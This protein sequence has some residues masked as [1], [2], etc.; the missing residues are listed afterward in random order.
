MRLDLD[1]TLESTSLRFIYRIYR[2]LR[3]SIQLYTVPVVYEYIPVGVAKNVY[4]SPARVALI[5][6]AVLHSTYLDTAVRLL[7]MLSKPLRHYCRCMM[8]A[9]HR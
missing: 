5:Y 2:V 9:P 6:R 7:L 8:R 3:H 1:V 4:S